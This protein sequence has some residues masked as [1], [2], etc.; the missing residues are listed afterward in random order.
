[1]ADVRCPMCGK[2]NDS[3]AEVC[4][5][6][7]A[8]IKPLFI[9]Q[10]PSEPEAPVEEP[11]AAAGGESEQEMPEWL[12]RIRAQAEAKAA[13][14]P[15]E[16]RQK[17]NGEEGDWLD[18]LRQSG[19]GEGSDADEGQPLPEWLGADGLTESA[20]EE[21]A[22]E[23][24]PAEAAAE[25]PDWLGGMPRADV[26]HDEGPPEGEVPE[27]LAQYEGEQEGE[28][29]EQVPEWLARIRARERAGGQV[30]GAMPAVETDWLNQLREGAI[31]QDGET[32]TAE[33][34]TAEPTPAAPGAQPPEEEPEVQAER[35]GQK[36]EV[37]HEPLP[38]LE[39]PALLSVP[40]EEQ[41][42]A[43]E[44][45][46]KPPAKEPD[47]LG[48]V[49]EIKDA[50]L[51]HVPALI[52]E[53]G[54]PAAPGGTQDL[55]LEAIDLPDWLG[56]LKETGAEEAEKEAKPDLAPA[57]LPAWLEAM[58][59]VETFRPAVEIEPEEDQVV[60]SAGPL[61]GLRGVLMAEPV[62]AMPRTPT[63]GG[64]K[65]D[66][67]E[68]QFAQ[69]ELLHRMVE[70]EER[71]ITPVPTTRGRLPLV[72]WALSLVLLL[73]VALPVFTGVPRFPLP[74]RLPLDLPALT[75]LVNSLPTERP[76]LVVFDY[77]PGYSGEL[78][79]VAGALFQH[80]V[81]REL[82]I[83]TVS[84]RPAGPP[85]AERLMQRVAPELALT[86]G[87]D[88]LHLGYLSGGPTA[89]QLFAALPR[90]A[91]LRGFLLPRD[92]AGASA[93]DSPLLRDVQGLSD[94]AAVVVI[95]AGTESAR[96][97]TEQA[98]PWMGDTPLIMV[99]SMGAEPLVRPYYEALEPQ[100]NGILTGLSA[101]VIYEQG[102]GRPAA[103]HD[104]WDGYGAGA[105]AAELAL[106]A[107][108]VYGA[109]GWLLQ[110]QRERG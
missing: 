49:G 78:D 40:Q 27:W 100:V 47:W 45:E 56:E 73:A 38:P 64:A 104:R 9:E 1:M 17:G 106:A 109:I 74:S 75:E 55:D 28:E 31:P 84:T 3:Q 36:P 32:P 63:V 96:T 11:A 54:E 61:A 94:F 16:E 53:T 101:A 6:C 34:P 87:E 71:E 76:V 14:E 37:E 79:A 24:Q 18:R 23:G 44:P 7:G 39:A 72:R 19:A 30:E 52:L 80:L 20:K 110:P 103:A 102:N 35:P 51:P 88:Y 82:R 97:W 13:P 25:E 107:G 93:W 26:G 85:L 43:V 99:L 2:A 66:I 90:E 65:L 95:T 22:P 57:T 60:E 12:A 92:L 15:E 81:A 108:L 59:P 10:P 68:R 86:N 77:D 21:P 70:E 105:L 58:R 69:A 91:I 42:P 83:I 41:P 46:P 33:P 48:E 4:E 29:E 67:T 98:R 50:T 62:V 8:R 89:V 5:F